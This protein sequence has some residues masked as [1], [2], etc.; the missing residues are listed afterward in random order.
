MCANTVSTGE[1]KKPVR[2]K[3]RA[4]KWISVVIVGILLAVFFGVPLFLSS[5]AG[6]VFVVNKVNKSLDGKIGMGDLNVGW[7]KGVR[8][9]EFSFADDKGMINV[10]VRQITAKPSYTSMLA[11]NIS[12]GK[13]VVDRPVISI[14]VDDSKSSDKTGAGK[15]S[16]KGKKNSGGAG[17]IFSQIDLTVKDGDIKILPADG[18]ISSTIH[19]SNIASKVNLK[20]A[21]K[22][23]SFNVGMDIENKGR[24]SKISANGN[25]ESSKKG[26]SFKNTEGDM[27]VKID[28]LDL[29]TLSPVFA[30]LGKDID[31]GGELNV[32]AEVKFGNGQIEKLI[33]D[34]K[35][36]RFK[37]VADGKVI[38][39]DKPV[40]LKALVS[41]KNDKV[42]IEDINLR[43][44]FCTIT[45]KGTG[46]ELDYVAD[47]DVGKTMDFVG[48]FVDLGDYSFTGSCYEEGRITFRDDTIRFSDHSKIDNF[49]MTKKD[50]KGKKSTPPMSA[51]FTFDMTVDTKKENVKIDF[52]T[53]KTTDS[54]ADI[55]IED[56][57]FSWAEDAK[58]KMDMNLKAEVDL[59][60]TKP[61]ALFFGAMSEKMNLSGLVKSKLLVR[62]SDSELK[63][64][65]DNTKITNFKLEAE[66]VKEKFED[67]LIN[68]RLDMVVDRDNKTLSLKE[69]VVDG[70]KIDIEGSIKQS[71]V[72]NDQTKLSG[73]VTA[74]Y[75]LADART[76]ASAYLPEGLEVQGKRSDVFTFQ[77]QYP[78]ADKD[79]LMANMN[80]SGKFGF[81]RAKYMGMKIGKVDVAVDVKDG[82][83]EIAPFSTSVNNGLLN[84]AGNIDLTKKPMVF[85]IPK[86]MQIIDKVEIDD[87]VG[88][89]LL[90]YLNP[91]FAEQTDLSG[92]ANLHC[93]KLVLPLGGDT[94]IADAQI[95]GTVA[96]S[97]MKMKNK[98][99]LG[100]IMSQGLGQT[101]MR[102]D[103]LP[104]KIVM[105]KGVIRYDNM[106]VNIDTVY[107]INFKGAVNLNKKPGD[108]KMTAAL[109]YT[110]SIRDGG[111]KPL[112]TDG[113]PKG[114]IE[115]PIEGT[116]EK[117]GIN[118][119][120]VLEGVGKKA[121][122]EFIQEGLEGLFKKKKKGSGG[123][124]SDE[125][126]I[127]EGILDLF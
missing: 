22:R 100:M 88:K 10:N 33:V 60:R 39:L 68:V 77:S 61:F 12:L 23:S 91:L 98:G 125:E 84:F 72:R 116:V 36:D 49:V 86:P 38:A 43:S 57:V 11:G 5:S 17:V 79:K 62:S 58:E 93:E 21:G 48:T 78:N 32:D 122:E 13:V 67:K 50:E 53:M 111:I 63:V 104:S 31:V 4:L 26:W 123:D 107:P 51:K 96:I 94:A 117:N 74:K 90:K 73:K 115:L 87:E 85:T 112:R 75:D 76:I 103:M 113:N 95:A 44:S 71:Q 56:S 16:A 54:L 114:R 52:L 37:H 55:R 18:E 70:T 41:T 42:N 102:A 24:R 89:A 92:I 124:K 108:L 99:L 19:F 64:F 1:E 35:L 126:K 9:K 59:A 8:L 34:A 29:A 121:V 14:R 20:E 127:I 25:V 110:L 106:Q 45:G 81:D 97:D 30:L 105:D 101:T 118:W 3:F 120:G 119:K 69:F 2:R 65:T 28:D 66:G 109:P 82:M 6:T 7:F 15:K 40:T 46:S 27:T 47:M 83:L 80:A